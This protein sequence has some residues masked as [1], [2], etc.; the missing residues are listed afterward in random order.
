MLAVAVLAAAGGYF[1]ARFVGTDSTGA[2]NPVP[3]QPD[4]IEGQRRPD[5]SH[6]DLEGRMVSPGDF[7]GQLLLINFWASW[8]AP[9]VEEM[10]MLSR[11]QEEYSG[12]RLKVLGIALDDPGRAADFAAGMELAYT[13]LVGEADVVVTG[14]R[15]GNVSGLLPYSVLVDTEGIVRWSH[16]GAL[17]RETIEKQ[18]WGASPIK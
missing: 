13:V 17:D 7:E 8:C 4:S 11:L 9:C 18:V 14:R 6:R 1:T 10:P 5:F 3:A 16:L 12:G 15:Y 2:L